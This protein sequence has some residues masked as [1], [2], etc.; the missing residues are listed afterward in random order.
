MSLNRI[1]RR[2]YAT[3]YSTDHTWIA[4]GDRN[5]GKF[6]FTHKRI[7][8]MQGVVYAAANRAAVEIELEST[9]AVFSVKAPLPGEIVRF[10]ENLFLNIDLIR[11]DPEN[12]GWLAQ[13]N[14]IDPSPK[15]LMTR[16]QYLRYIKQK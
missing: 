3:Y 9:N 5:H 13:I 11:D 7:E 10:N 4:L 2:A 14:P 15:D 8:K 12:E 6:G 1:F 16:K